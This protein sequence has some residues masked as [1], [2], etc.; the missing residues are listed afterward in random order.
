MDGRGGCCIARYTGEAGPYDYNLSKA[1]R[2]MLRFRP[3]A[4]KPTTSDGGGGTSVS[5]GGGSSDVVSFRGG[6]G[7]RKYQQK[8]NVGN[9]TRCTRRKRSDKSIVHGGATTVTLSLMPE[10]PDQGA[11]TD[12][13][14]TVVPSEEKQK[15]RSPFWL[16]FSD[17]GQMFTPAYNTVVISSCMTV[18]RITD[19]WIDG[20]GLGRSDEER[21]MNLVRDT[22]PGFISD[23]SGRVTW[24]NDAYRKMARDN[25]HVEEGAPEDTSMIVRLVMRESPMRT[26]PAFTCRVKL[27]YTCQDR[28]RCVVAV[29][30]DVWRMDAGGFAWRLDVK[31]ALC[32]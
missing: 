18:E 15:R 9:A 11:F 14:V 31:A 1:D 6:R 2:I 28:E 19:A 25:I 30:C 26:Y 4:P 3:I 12:R 23:G 20:Y 17:G 29:P 5:S 21:K 32:L 16:S 22:C 10:T 24:T 7:K 13:K 8:E 27:Q